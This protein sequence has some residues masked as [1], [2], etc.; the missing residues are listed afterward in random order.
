[1]DMQ[2]H[3]LD[4]MQWNTMA[5]QTL[6][7]VYLYLGQRLQLVNLQ[8]DSH[9]CNHSRGAGRGIHV[10]MPEFPADLL[11]AASSGTQKTTSGCP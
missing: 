11:S 7:S 3:E 6:V 10:G 9:Q 2:G 4:N 1:M 5:K 8:G